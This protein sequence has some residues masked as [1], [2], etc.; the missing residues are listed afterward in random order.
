MEGVSAPGKTRIPIL[1]AGEKVI[2][3]TH[4]VSYG[5]M[6]SRVQVIAAYPIT[7][8]TAIVER[9]SEACASGQ[10]PA[11]FIC[12]ESEHSA[13]AACI[14]A[15]LAGVR[16]FT[17]T[18]A[19]GLALM[20]E[21]LHWAAGIRAPV[22]M[23][24]VNRG[25]SPPWV[26]FADQC[27]S[28]SQRDTGWMQLYCENNQEVL[29]TVIQAYRVA[30]QVL[31]PCMLNLDGF[32]LSHVSER[33]K[34]PDGEEVDAYLPPYRLP[35]RLDARQPRSFGG[36]C[37]SGSFY[38]ELRYKMHEALVGAVE[39]L[40][41][42]DEEFRQRFG[43]GYGVVEEYHCKDADL[44]LVT[45]GSATGT[46]RTVVDGLRE[47]GERVG[48]LKVRLFRPFPAE[49]IRAVA[50]RVG[51]L[52]VLDRNISYGQS[53][54]FCQEIRAAL[55]GEDRHPPVFGFVAGLGGQDI[56]PERIAEIIAYAQERDRP[57]QDVI[58]MGL[59]R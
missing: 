38:P 16:T 33:V 18:S 48:L 10:F 43:R 53:G 17:A 45:S 47:Q 51:K 14:G 37:M 52:A 41:R 59:R 36:I 29:D 42:A 22:V 56:T 19:Q 55:S 2:E 21:M 50:R 39:A 1:Q 13:M 31:M 5:V 46:A 57:E 6:L 7:P 26:I 30:E 24:N 28:L 3:A 25:M 32:Y 8:Q 12:V 23:A 44:V 9:L 58:W 35:Y 27:D 11:R 20:H 49:E 4:A 15:A 54:I 34:I 40:R